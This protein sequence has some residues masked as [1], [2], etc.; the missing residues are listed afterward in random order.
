MYNTIYDKILT[1]KF[2]SSVL[3]VWRVDATEMESKHR[4]C[5]PPSQLSRSDAAVRCPRHSRNTVVVRSTLVFPH[6]SPSIRSHHHPPISS[7]SLGPF[8]FSPAVTY[9]HFHLPPSTIHLYTFQAFPSP[10]SPLILSYSSIP[11]FSFFF[12]LSSISTLHVP[13]FILPIFP[14]PSILPW[15]RT[16]GQWSDS[17][18]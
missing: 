18:R 12:L 10:F 15:W 8:P 7:L 6:W 1:F 13:S 16:D 17:L 11:F 3:I 2:V 4:F 14:F 9:T 5:K